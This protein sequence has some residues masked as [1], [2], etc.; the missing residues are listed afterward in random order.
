MKTTCSTVLVLLAFLLTSCGT[1]EGALTFA[2]HPLFAGGSCKGSIGGK[3]ALSWPAPVSVGKHE[4]VE[5]QILETTNNAPKK[6]IEVDFMVVNGNDR[7]VWLELSNVRVSVNGEEW[8]AKGLMRANRQ[9][10]RGQSE[11]KIPVAFELPAVAAGAIYH[12]VMRDLQIDST[13]GL[14]PLVDV[15]EFD[16]PVAGEAVPGA[17]GG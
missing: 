7:A 9:E 15:L 4:N 10:I 3:L 11:K 12:V 16:I 13:D 1:C 2:D 6:K 14:K 8:G 17:A 5:I